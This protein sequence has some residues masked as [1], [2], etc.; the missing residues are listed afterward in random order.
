VKHLGRSNRNYPLANAAA[1]ECDGR[2]ISA[3]LRGIFQTLFRVVQH[4]LH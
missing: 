2:A 3:L 1:A 4:L